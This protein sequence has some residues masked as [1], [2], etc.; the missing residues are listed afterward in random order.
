MSNALWIDI[1]KVKAALEKIALIKGREAD[2]ARRAIICHWRGSPPPSEDYAGYVLE[3]IP[4]YTAKNIGRFLDGF[5]QN[6]VKAK[7]K[8]CPELYTE[9]VELETQ[10]DAWNGLEN[11]DSHIVEDM[12]ESIR[13]LGA[14]D[15]DVERV[16]TLIAKPEY[17]ARP[18]SVFRSEIQR[19]EKLRCPDA[20]EEG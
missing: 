19:L 1:K 6:G 5:F 9:I 8:N 11:R 17:A 12:I 3:T 15:S 14:T 2:S 18:L 7:W 10:W 4:Y 16:K 20:P 13:M